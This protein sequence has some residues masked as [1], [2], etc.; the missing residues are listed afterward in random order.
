[1]KTKI[2]FILDKVFL[3]AKEILKLHTSENNIFIQVFPILILK[4]YSIFVV[5]FKLSCK[6]IQR[7]HTE[8]LNIEGVLQE[9]NH[10]NKHALGINW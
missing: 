8:L 4:P 2:I 9:K 10:L 6:C 7:S 1:M 3:L 5:L